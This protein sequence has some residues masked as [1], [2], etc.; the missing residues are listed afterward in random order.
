MKC[1]TVSG[2]IYYTRRSVWDEVLNYQPYRALYPDLVGAFLPTPM[3]FEET[4]YSQIVQFLGYDV[5]YDGTVNTAGHTWNASTG[6]HDQRLRSLF[7]ESRKMYIDTCDALGI[8][9]ECH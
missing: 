4:F 1:W 6:S 8:P 7:A 9:H 2:S 3:Y 5:W